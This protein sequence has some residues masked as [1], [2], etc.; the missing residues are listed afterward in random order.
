MKNAI[1][2]INLKKLGVLVVINSDGITKGV[3][4]IINRYSH[5]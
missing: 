1:R 5:K 2:V 3:F 4:T